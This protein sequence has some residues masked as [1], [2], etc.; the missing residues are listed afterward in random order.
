ML[1]FG[2]PFVMQFRVLFAVVLLV[3]VGGSVFAEPKA[4]ELVKYRGK[5]EGM[6]FVLNYGDGYAHASEMWVTE[7]K[8]GKSARFGLDDSGQM[9]FV[10]G[11]QS[12]GKREIILK[13]GMDEGAPDKVEGTY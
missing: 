4:Y 10:P 1:R 12:G 8:S 6:S 3:L 5:A 13:M 11:K 9:R 7:R 2:K